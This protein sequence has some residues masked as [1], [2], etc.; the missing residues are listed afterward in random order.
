MLLFNISLRR[1]YQE[2]AVVVVFDIFKVRYIVIMITSHT[3]A[4]AAAAATVNVTLLCMCEVICYF[5][6]SIF[7]HAMCM[8]V[9]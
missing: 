5:I 7:F 6:L 4:A 8:C 2:K 1:P 3:V 9:S